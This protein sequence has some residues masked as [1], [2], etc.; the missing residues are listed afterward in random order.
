M[1]RLHISQ[2]EHRQPVGRNDIHRNLSTHGAHCNFAVLNFDKRRAQNDEYIS[3]H[4]KH[5]KPSGYPAQPN[6][7][8]KKCTGAELVGNRINHFT[9]FR[10]GICFTCYQPIQIIR[11]HA[12]DQHYDDF[13][14]VHQVVA[15]VDVHD[16]KGN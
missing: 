15:V 14:I 5:Q 13:S 10:N 12:I 8:N 9:N 7:V 11:N 16:R 6:G 3:N 1:H 4:K 2:K